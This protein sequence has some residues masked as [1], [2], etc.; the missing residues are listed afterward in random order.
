MPSYIWGY[1]L[2]IQ[3]SCPIVMWTSLIILGSCLIIININYQQ[4]SSGSN[5]HHKQAG[6]HCPVGTT[7]HGTLALPGYRL[8]LSGLMTARRLDLE[9]VGQETGPLLVT[10]D[11]C[12]LLGHL[13]KQQLLKCQHYHWKGEDSQYRYLHLLTAVYLA[14]TVTCWLLGT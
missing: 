3:G 13:E 2:I 11:L 8:E 4:T 1:C 14:T 5:C 6:S 10:L 12:H 7:L 9:L